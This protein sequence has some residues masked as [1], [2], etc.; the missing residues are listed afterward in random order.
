MK[1]CR[2]IKR[3]KRERWN[4][5]SAEFLPVISRKLLKLLPAAPRFTG[6]LNKA[7][8]Y[9]VKT[10]GKRIRPLLF[11]A[12]TRTIK[13]KISRGKPEKLVSFACGIEFIHNYSLVH[14]DIMD[15][16]DTRRGCPTVHRKFGADVAILT[17]DA[18]L[19]RGLEILYANFP[20]SAGILNASIGIPGMISGQAADLQYE[21]KISRAALR[22]IHENKT[23]ALFSGICR[24]AAVAMSRKENIANL[25][26]DFGLN[27]GMSFQV[28]DDLLDRFGKHEKFRKSRTDE[29]NRKLTAL[30]FY[31]ERE[32]RKFVR[33]FAENAERNL[34]SLPGD[35]G[36]LR[37]FISVLS[38]RE[39]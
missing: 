14:D 32:C 12:V 26:E 38:R 23:A 27:V 39:K 22:Y 37:D 5:F 17:G 11:L 10:G 30:S 28:M 16:D 6:E 25:F 18:L 4:K 20:A 21:K 2:K 31:S 24:A 34:V 15:S 8:E 29:K 1:S 7:L 35:A 33:D 13:E 9:T 36:V 19:T 3:G